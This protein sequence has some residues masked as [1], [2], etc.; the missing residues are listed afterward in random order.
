MTE[1]PLTARKITKILHDAGH[2]LFHCSLQAEGIVRCT[3]NY[4][5]HGA[6]AAADTRSRRERRAQMAVD[7]LTQAGYV[8][9]RVDDRVRVCQPG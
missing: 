2:G 1:K 5:A 4:V 9:D 3:Q 7:V 8:A 6:L